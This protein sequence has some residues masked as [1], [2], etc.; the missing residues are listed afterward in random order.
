VDPDEVVS[1]LQVEAAGRTSAAFLSVFENGTKVEPDHY[2]VYFT[3]KCSRLFSACSVTI[4]VDFEFGR[5]HVWAT[6][7]A[8][9]DLLLAGKPLEINAA[10]QRVH[11]IYSL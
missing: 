6:R 4:P 8:L 5:L 2:V 10:A 11:A 1:I 9:V 3:C 7:K